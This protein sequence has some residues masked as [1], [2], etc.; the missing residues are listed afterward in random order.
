MSPNDAKS[1]I[2][3]RLGPSYVFI[4]IFNTNRIKL[5]FFSFCIYFDSLMRDWVG[6]NDENKPEVNFL[7]LYGVF[8][9]TNNF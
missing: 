7:Y 4:Y 9:L 5:M 1:G 3:R 8:V 6:S 2:L